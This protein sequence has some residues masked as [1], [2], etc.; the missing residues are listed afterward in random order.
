ME[1][2]NWDELFIAT[3]VLGS[4]RGTCDRL[5]AACFLVKNKR[6]VGAG[7]NG[8]MANTPTCDEVGHDLLN[9]HCV[10]TLHAEQNAL[11]NS[12]GD[13]HGATAYITATP[14]LNC[15]KELGQKGIARIVYAGHYDN[16]DDGR[17]Y[18]YCKQ[19]QIELVQFADDAKSVALVFKKIF[20][21]LQGPGGIFKDLALPE[22][23]FGPRH[24]NMRLM[25][26]GKLIIFEGI[27]GCGKS[28]QIPLLADDL[29]K[30]GYEVVVTH[31]PGG[32]IPSIREQILG[33]NPKLRKLAEVEL[34]LFV[35]DRAVHYATLVIPALKEG[36]IVICSRGPR[37]TEAFQGYG[38][39]MDLQ[40]IKELNKVATQGVE[41]NL[42][43]FLDMN[44]QDALER[45]KKNN[46]KKAD[47]FE[48][49]LELQERV[50]NGYIK[51]SVESRDTSWQVIWAAD[52]ADTVSKKIKKVVEERLGI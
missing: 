10:R 23:L 41:A 38:R 31:E 30:K 33:L 17:I 8:S 42:T 7:Y 1:R 44:P 39:G 19:G 49:D 51:E 26:G 6:I 11:A 29:S 21:R 52:D 37:A 16:K 47:R 24:A 18:E 25:G 36:K 35:I 43:L 2:P 28:T 9:D 46:S 13:L 22:I 27:D 3:A 15:I 32:G 40:R 12:W 50:K 45:M 5:R 20:D 34:E 4:S 48:K 14:C